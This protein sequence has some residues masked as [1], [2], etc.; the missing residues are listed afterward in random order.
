M[1]EPES[2]RVA[3]SMDAANALLAI[4][5]LFISKAERLSGIWFT[6]FNLL[7]PLYF[8]LVCFIIRYLALFIF[9]L[10]YST[11]LCFTLIQF[12]FYLYL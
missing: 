4:L 10:L 3:V 12:T 2:P 6:S 9:A 7:I 1:V 5:L 11:V 8:S